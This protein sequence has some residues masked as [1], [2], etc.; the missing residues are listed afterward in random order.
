MIDNN[1]VSFSIRR[2]FKMKKTLIIISV[3][4]IAIILVLSF[5]LNS[6]IKSGVETVGS[7]ATDTTVKLQDVDISL[8]SGKGQIKNLFIGN[9]EGFKTESAFKLNEV[10]LSL[11]VKSVFSDKIVI[12]EIYIDAPDITYE[13]GFKGDN[14]KAILK[15]IKAFS[16]ESKGAP[17]DTGEK[18]S[19]DEKNVQIN[20]FIVKNGKVNMSVT[21]LR[22]EKLS[23]SLPDI[24]MKDIGKEKEGTTM[25]KALEQVFVV[26]NKNVITAVAGSVKDIDIG[27][28]VEE[29]GGETVGNTVNKLKGLIGK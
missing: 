3:L 22:G 14:I 2:Y 25:S 12:D 8:F 29:A 15:N 13:K 26:I 9:P 6:I 1:A 23:L 17:M 21:A 10:R 27:S 7:K 28:V 20:N 11:N 19:K 4:I 24:H 16:G 18:S 5:S